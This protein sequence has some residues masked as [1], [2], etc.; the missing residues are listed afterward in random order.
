MSSSEYELH[1]CLLDEQAPPRPQKERNWKLMQDGTDFVAKYTLNCKEQYEPFSLIA[2]LVSK[3]SNLAHLI[4]FSE[5]N[6][7]LTS[8]CQTH[9]TLHNLKSF[10]CC[11]VFDRLDTDV[12][13]SIKSTDL[14]FGTLDGMLHS[15]ILNGGRDAFAV[16]ECALAFSSRLIDWS[17]RPHLHVLGKL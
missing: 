10:C 5:F 6:I 17:W 3:A 12:P 2:D 9:L 14:S 15:G 8:T 7:D 1:S 16:F 13:P 4:K 11:R